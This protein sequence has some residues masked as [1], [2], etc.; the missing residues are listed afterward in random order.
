MNEAYAPIYRRYAVAFLNIF[1]EKIDQAVCKN[2]QEAS[3]TL[4]AHRDWLYFFE[5]P[6]ITSEQQSKMIRLLLDKL[7][8]PHF[9]DR[10]L[11]LMIDHKRVWLLPE[12]LDVLVRIFFSRHNL[13][14]FSLHSYPMLDEKQIDQFKTFLSKTSGKRI[15]MQIEVDASLICGIRARSLTRLWEHSIK[16][17][18][19]EAQHVMYEQG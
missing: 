8:M 7:N 3:D 13:M 16:K 12:T 17:K 4:R 14:H 1:Y 2:V 15:T 6:D 9:F 10:L 18:L 19:R 5:L 11:Y